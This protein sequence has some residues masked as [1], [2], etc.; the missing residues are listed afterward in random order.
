MSK[1]S[2]LIH[3]PTHMLPKIIKE[4]G[5]PAYNIL[6]VCINLCIKLPYL[7]QTLD[8]EYEATMTESVILDKK[9][10]NSY[11]FLYPHKK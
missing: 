8:A 11:H 9:E 7:K 4:K 1:L 6:N 2:K 10:K 3:F 5:K